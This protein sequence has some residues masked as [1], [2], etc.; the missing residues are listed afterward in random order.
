MFTSPLI[1]KRIAIGK[2]LGF[3]LG[4]TV[5]IFDFETNPETDLFVS[6]GF[7]LWYIMFGALIGIMG[8]FDKHPALELPFPWWFR[9]PAIGAWL[10]LT[11]TLIA[12]EKLQQIMLA[13]IGA[14][15]VF[16]SPF[17]FV[18]EGAILGFILDA[19]IT[20]FCGDGLQTAID[21]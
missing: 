18:L 4:L 15:S 17:W 12:Y 8:L 3:L 13:Y 7:F 2:G 6:F 9:G 11:I 19:I 1:V 16:H 21:D 20:R 10:N 14:D 5:F